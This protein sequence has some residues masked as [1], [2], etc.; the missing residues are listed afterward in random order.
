MLAAIDAR[1]GIAEY[2]II[3]LPD[4][5]LEVHR[6]PAPMTDQPL[7]HHYRSI[8]RLTKGDT[9]SPLAQPDSHIAVADLLP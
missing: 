3:N 1:A 9:L 2:W 6:Q 7:G 5:V 8:T 4:S